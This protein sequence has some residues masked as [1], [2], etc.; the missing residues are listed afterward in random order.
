MP[1]ETGAAMPDAS[2]HGRADQRRA[3]TPPNPGR[4][5]VYVVRPGKKSNLVVRNLKDVALT[6]PISDLLFC[7]G[8]LLP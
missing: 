2:S 6:D 7:K 4:P 5:F 1:N 3:E 8:K